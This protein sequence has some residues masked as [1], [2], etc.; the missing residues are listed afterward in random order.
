MDRIRLLAPHSTREHVEEIGAV[1]RE[2]RKAVAL[3]GYRAQIEE[4]PRL[5]GIPEADFL[6]LRLAR[7]GLELLA[8]PERV[9]DPR[10]VGGELDARANF[11]QRIR[12]LVNVDIYAAPE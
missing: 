12:L 7:K 1:N 6:A 8:Y 5:A 9:E 4:L 10:A 3:D 2:I 11:L